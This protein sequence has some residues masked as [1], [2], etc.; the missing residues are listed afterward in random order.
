MQ[1]APKSFNE[2]I[3]ASLNKRVECILGCGKIITGVVDDISYFD[4][5]GKTPRL[6]TIT[7]Y[8]SYFYYVEAIRIIAISIGKRL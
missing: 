5:D 8:D 6:V 7:G 1:K 4:D 3:I 2:V